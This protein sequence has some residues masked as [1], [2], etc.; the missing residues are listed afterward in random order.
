MPA[1]T[2][3]SPQHPARIKFTSFLYTFNNRLIASMLS[4]CLKETCGIASH[5]TIQHSLM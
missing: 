2:K 1:A 3:L 5:N 4:E